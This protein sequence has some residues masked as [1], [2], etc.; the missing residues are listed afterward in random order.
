VQDGMRVLNA[1]LKEDDIYYGENA[2]IVYLLRRVGVIE[3]LCF[4]PFFC[5]PFLSF[6]VLYLLASSSQLSDG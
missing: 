2:L 3:L 4:L 6:D 5:T 1:V